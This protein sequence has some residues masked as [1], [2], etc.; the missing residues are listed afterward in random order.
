MPLRDDLLKPISDEKPSGEN[1]KYSPVVDKIKEARRQEDDAPQGEWQRERKVADYALVVKLAS[2]ALAT[3]TKDLQLAGWLTEA[4]LH[5]EGFSGLLQGLQLIRGLIENFWDTVH[6]LVEEEEDLELRAAPLNYVGFYLDTQIRNTPLI[7]GGHTYLGYKQSRSIP[8]E[9]DAEYDEAK[10]DTRAS[11]VAEGK[12]LPEE[13]EKSFAATSAEDLNETFEQL[14]SLLDLIDELTPMCEEK[15]GVEFTPS[16]A[17]LRSAIEEVH[18]TVRT[19]V[20][21]KGEPPKPKQAE[22]EETVEETSSSYEES[23][24]SYESEPAPVVR[25]VARKVTSAQPVDRDD[26][27][28]RVIAVAQF[29][30]EQDSYDPAPFLLLRGLRWGEL[31]AG[32]SSPDPSLFEAPPTEIRQQI[33]RGSM[34]GS[35]GDVLQACE[36]A[37]GMPCGRAWL[38]LQRY[39]V[40]ACEELGY[41]AIADAIKSGVRALLADY[42]D[43]PNAS[44]MDDTPTANAETQ[45]W[46]KEIAPPPAAAAQESLYVPPP[47]METEEEEA[48]PFGEEAPP[49][50]F[51]LASDAARNGRKQEAFEIMTQEVA[52]QTTGRGRFQR[53]KQLAQLCIAMGH[54]NIAQSILEQLAGTIDEHKLETWESSD[55]VAHALSMLY[56]CMSKVDS[57]DPAEKQRLYTRICRLDPMQALAHAR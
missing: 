57:T 52:R 34:D 43:L 25:K 49:D 16:F 30:R 18:N 31:R 36:T 35:W 23:S 9:Q 13:W 38:D 20:R 22:P 12:L 33:K 4:M 48:R 2:E 11:A 45:A 14:T 51:E 56:E 41:Q 44:M 37:A 32:G 27:V 21:A 26:A 7:D 17:K 6:P 50:A 55:V 42:P 3:K 10:R 46:L 53:K 24:S 15:F 8:N 5:R 40:K 39:T 54:E 28:D 29:L 47:V 19:F 1:M